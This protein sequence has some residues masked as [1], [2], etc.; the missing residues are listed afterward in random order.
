[1]HNICPVNTAGLLGLYKYAI[2]FLKNKCTASSVNI[3]K[4]LVCVCMCVFVC[5]CG[6]GCKCNLF[7]SPQYC[8]LSN[9][10]YNYSFIF[11][12]HSVILLTLS[13]WPFLLSLFIFLKILH[14]IATQSQTPELCLALRQ[15]TSVQAFS[16]TSV[17]V[18]DPLTD[19][20]QLLPKL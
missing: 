17:G 13:E 12:T 18:T 5:V 15:A 11:P 1:M 4:N 8:I 3:F 6:G 19:L 16:Q 20:C 7:H 9:T 10:K 14:E 2:A